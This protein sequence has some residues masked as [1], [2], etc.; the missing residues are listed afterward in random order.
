MISI[1]QFCTIVLDGWLAIFS[2]WS[3]NHNLKFCKGGALC[4]FFKILQF[5]VFEYMKKKLI[6]CLE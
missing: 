3:T 2:F 5:I 4:N 1:M 6:K